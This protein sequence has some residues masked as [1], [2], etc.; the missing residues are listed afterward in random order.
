MG[1]GV[2]Y[3]FYV[4]GCMCMNKGGMECADSMDETFISGGV[5]VEFEHHEPLSLPVG[6]LA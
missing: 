3:D 6:V 4:G 1:G 2:L 5:L